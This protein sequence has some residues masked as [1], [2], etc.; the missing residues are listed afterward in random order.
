MYLG[1]STLRGGATIHWLVSA[2]VGIAISCYFTVYEKQQSSPELDSVSREGTGMT[3]S[4]SGYGAA[5]RG[6]HRSNTAL[7]TG[8][9]DEEIHTARPDVF[10]ANEKA[11]TKSSVAV[12]PPVNTAVLI[13]PDADYPWVNPGD[14]TR[15]PVNVGQYLDAN[16]EPPSLSTNGASDIGTISIDVGQHLSADTEPHQLVIAIDGDS[17]HTDSNVGH[18]LDPEAESP[19]VFRADQSD[20]RNVGSFIDADI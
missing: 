11:T 2:L 18:Y 20:Q 17:R 10:A 6:L 13:D 9:L 1:Y 12:L 7:K 8:D 19:G 15:M 5:E 16:S 3:P 4:A 14:M